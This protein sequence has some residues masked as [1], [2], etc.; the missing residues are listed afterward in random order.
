MCRRFW[1]ISAYSFA[2]FLVDFACAF[3]VFRNILQAPDKHFCVLLYN[4]CAF[5]MQMPLGILADKWNRNAGLAIFGCLLVSVAYGF[6]SLPIVATVVVGMG[7]ALFHIGGGVDVLNVSEKKLGA[8]GVFVSPG[9]LGIYF[10]AMLGKGNEVSSFPI[11]LALV[12]VA[13]VIFV[14][15]KMQGGG[16][17]KNAVFSLE[18][19]FSSKILFAVACL[20]LVVCLRSYVGLRLSFPWKGVGYWGVIWVCAVV[21]GKTAGG[22]LADRFGMRGT[23]FFSLGVAALLFLFPQTPLLGVMAVLLFNMTMPIT[24]FGMAKLFPGAKGFS[25]GLLTFALFLGFVPVH[26]GQGPLTAAWPFALAA[27]LSL[28]LLALGLRNLKA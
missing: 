28:V 26:L 9:A 17:P 4:F 24:L 12:G 27:A 25:F 5:A 21:L 23:L 10:G 11:L 15:H 3:L 13:G 8:L 20:F 1:L 2:H 19:V 14:A 7:N 6:V 16:Y 22:F 18:G